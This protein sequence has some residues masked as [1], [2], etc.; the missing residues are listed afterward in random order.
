M[1]PKPKDRLPHQ[2]TT[3]RSTLRRTEQTTRTGRAD[4]TSIPDFTLPSPPA[5][6][7]LHPNRKTQETRLNHLQPGAYYNAWANPQ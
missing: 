2:T 6:K 7:L 3:Q 4:L 5:P 1:H